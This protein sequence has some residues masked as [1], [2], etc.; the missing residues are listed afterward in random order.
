MTRVETNLPST[1]VGSA[2]VQAA[3]KEEAKKLRP[4]KQVI[5]KRP[6]FSCFNCLVVF[7][8]II[9]VLIGWVLMLVAKTGFVD[10]PL[11]T[12]WFYQEPKPI[13]EVVIKP[14]EQL[15]MDQQALRTTQAMQ[16]GQAVVFT[17]KELTL[18]VQDSIKQLNQTGNKLTIESGQIAIEPE[19]AELFVKL[20][21]PVSGYLAIGFIPQ[22]ENRNLIFVPKKVKIG[23]LNVPVVVAK[24][25][26]DQVINS[27]LKNSLKDL[28]LNLKAVRLET[29]KMLI[30]FEVD[31]NKLKTNVK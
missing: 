31:V 2:D 10:I 30:D 7:L 5:T 13:H 11:F 14:G 18:L 17:D 12:D 1:E 4:E 8:I 27:E 24:I 22:L 26:F 19:E 15:T 28:P 6:L 20:A 16:V 29:G 21:T 3:I 23:D 25:I 9:A